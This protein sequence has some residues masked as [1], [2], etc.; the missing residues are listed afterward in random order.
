MIALWK[1]GRETVRAPL[2]YGDL[3]SGIMAALNDPNTRGKIYEAMGPNKYLQSDLMDWMHEVM[4]KDAEDY[5]YKRVD[6]LLSP[7]TIAK[8]IYCS[9]TPIGNIYFAGPTLERLERVCSKY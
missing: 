2:F 5:G 1:K 4:H 8:S 6:L 7:I 9:L 3:V